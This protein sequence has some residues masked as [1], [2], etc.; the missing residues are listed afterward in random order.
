MRRIQDGRDDAQDGLDQLIYS[1]RF[2]EKTFAVD[3]GDEAR[4]R[5]LLALLNGTD[6]D[7]ASESSATVRNLWNRF[8]DIEL[9]YPED[10]RDE[11]LPF[12]IC[13][14]LERVMLVDI[15]TSDGGLALENCSSPR[16]R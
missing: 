14:L 4:R 8:A 12:F 11:E 7:V 5:C 10:L 3:D 13:W 6:F 2:G 9:L 15:S 16:R 1:N